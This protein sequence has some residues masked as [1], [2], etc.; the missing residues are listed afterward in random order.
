MQF[1]H[2]ECVNTFLN[3]AQTWIKD[4]LVPDMFMTTHLYGHSENDL[5]LKRMSIKNSNVWNTYLQP[6]KTNKQNL[7]IA[8]GGSRSLKVIPEFKTKTLTLYICYTKSSS[9]TFRIY[10]LVATP[11][12]RFLFCFP[13][14]KDKF[15]SESGMWPMRGLNSDIHLIFCLSDVHLSFIFLFGVNLSIFCALQIFE[16]ILALILSPC[17][18]AK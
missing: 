18:K 4:D 9:E 7:F 2:L 6:C 12:L 10:F 5:N 16:K 1:K 3:S 17:S 15:R 14:G 11:I 8:Y 13:H